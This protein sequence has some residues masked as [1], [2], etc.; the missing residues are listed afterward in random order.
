MTGMRTL[1]VAAA[2]SLLSLSVVACGDGGSQSL[3]GPAP[4]GGELKTLVDMTNGL[5]VTAGGT[6]TF[7]F[8]GQSFVIPGTG[9]YSG[10]RFHW[11]SFQRTPVA[12]GTLTLL[13]QEYLGLPGD[14]GPSTPGFVARSS[15]PR[16]NVY[17]FSE[18]VTLTAGTKYWV[19][20][21]TQG[22]FAGSFDQDIYPDGDE[23]VTGIRSQPFRKTR[24]SGRMVGGV[25]VPGPVGVFTDNN[26]KLQARQQ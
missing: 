1:S 6:G 8:A 18:N 4:P 16:D 20:T 9:T 15:E 25:F 22:S 19:Y 3:G 7:N 2:A 26:F 24:A 17:E 10:A 12:F 21:D 23:Y 13:T 5:E 11:Y 14:L